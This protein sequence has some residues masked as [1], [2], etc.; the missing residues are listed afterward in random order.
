MKRLL[1]EIR[2]IALFYFHALVCLVFLGT[3]NIV[4]YFWH[5]DRFE[6]QIFPRSHFQMWSWQIETV[7]LFG[8][9]IFIVGVE[10]RANAES[11]CCF[12][13]LAPR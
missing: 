4:L 1:Q 2:L 12:C 10:I 9:I 7:F 5:L 6:L 11:N 8:K 3:I 13:G